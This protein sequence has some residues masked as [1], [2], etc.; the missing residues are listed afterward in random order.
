MYKVILIT[1]LVVGM[2]FTYKE[3]REDV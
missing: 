3:W 1:M 2:Y